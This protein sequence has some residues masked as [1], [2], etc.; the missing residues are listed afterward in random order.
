MPVL[1]SSLLAD[2]LAIH[3]GSG[4]GLITGTVSAG[5]EY[6]VLTLQFDLND[7]NEQH[8]LLVPYCVIRAQGA[9]W[10]TGKRA[11]ENATTTIGEDF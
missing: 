2:K 6:E 1:K 9:I 7:V 5:A 8:G 10:I 11:L 3:K 4:L